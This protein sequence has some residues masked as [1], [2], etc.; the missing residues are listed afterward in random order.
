M[1]KLLA[2]VLALVMTMSL[3]TISNAA[4]KDANSIDYKEAVEVMNKVGVLIG[5]E[6]GN[7][8]A[9]DTL[10]R[11][12]AAKIVAYLDLG[13]KTAD[14][15]KGSGAVFTD[16]K[17]TDWFAGYVEYCAG[18]GYVAGMGDKTFAPN[19]KVT[20][21]QF[22]KMLLCALGYK[23]EIEGYTGS[24][25]TIAIARDANKND[26]FKSLSIVTSAN[27]TREQAAQMA[28]N[29]LEATVVEY[30]GG[31]NV[32]TSDGTSVIV[33]AV[34]NEVKRTSGKDY[35]NGKTETANG[36]QQLVE[37]LY[38]ADLILT[39][40]DS[41]DFGAPAEKWSYKN[42]EVGTY[43]SDADATFTKK[44]TYGDLYTAIGS[45][46]LKNVDKY[47]VKVDN[48]DKTSDVAKA[49]ITK[50]SDEEIAF[51]GKGV[52]TSVYVKDSTTNAG[53][54]DVT[55]VIVNTYVGKVSYVAK[56]TASADRYINITN[57]GTS[58]D[59]KDNGKFETEAF[60]KDD[61]VLF[62]A[63][64]NNS[65][66]EVKTVAAAEKVSAAEV[67]TMKG[68]S[69]FTAAGTTY[70]YAAT[71]NASIEIGNAYDLYLDANG[72]VAYAELVNEAV[73]YSNYIV[74]TNDAKE[75]GLG[76]KFIA[77]AVKMDGTMVSNITLGKLDSKK[78]NAVSTTDAAAGEGVVKIARNQL[79]SFTVG[80][81][82]KYNLKKVADPYQRAAV[83]LAN[84]NGGTGYKYHVGYTKL[85]GTYSANN[86]TTFVVYN[87]DKDTVTV[88]NGIKNMVNIANA[89]T[90]TTDVL[91]KSAG[92]A[93]L[94]FINTNATSTNA[95]SAKDLVY[96]LDTTPRQSKVG[97]DIIYTYA[98][99]VNGEVGTIAVKGSEITSAA[100]KL[101]YVSAYDG[102]YVDSIEDA[103][104]GT[105][106]NY[107]YKTATGKAT[108]YADGVFTIKDT[109]PVSFVLADK[110]ALYS[111][112]KDG[113]VSTISAD[114]LENTD[115]SIEYTV[116][117]KTSNKV[118]EAIAIYVQATK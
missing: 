94:V 92:T 43:A 37:K 70:K 7:F 26:L 105:P 91:Y 39:E 112:D 35:R 55:I 4:F 100:Q 62:T 88:Y 15:I 102:E 101:Y 21:V 16:V 74:I 72:Y 76:D 78:I 17:A 85:D 93:K 45:T 54:Y 41:N 49:N 52:T 71:Y 84:D 23:A 73:D 47:A 34:R 103:K 108:T 111:I 104:D 13:G 29:A 113:N 86:A 46:A 118:V 110:C 40:T 96:L 8:N 19:E 58:V 38:G 106:E 65:K 18:A 115:T 20:G 50:G 95:A 81:D 82:G 53:K 90:V 59:L 6:K 44:V 77:N 48:M 114:A 75:S 83:T 64:W 24:D 107:A 99:L 9:K 2:L 27:L 98:A 12:Q 97:D 25:Y 42:A 11:G 109:T 69:E 80:S 68:N 31:T 60:A 14:A 10:T 33:N 32:T 66:Y 3:V 61:Y 79:Y 30:Q 1:K 28:F 87:N 89:A 116:V 22:A 63:A 56:A 36:T 51:T 5:D 67:T 117:T 57:K